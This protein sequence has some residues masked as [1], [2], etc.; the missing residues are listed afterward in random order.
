[1]PSVFHFSPDLAIEVESRRPRGGIIDASTSAH[2]EVGPI[3]ALY[4]RASF[5]F[6]SRERSFINDLDVAVD[7][8]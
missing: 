5:D 1:M 4:E 6:F 8:V 3:A 7:S 2:I